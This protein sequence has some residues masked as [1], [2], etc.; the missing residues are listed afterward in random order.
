MRTEQWWN[1]NGKGGRRAAQ[2]NSA[3]V[4]FFHYEK[5]IKSPGNKPVFL[6]YETL[7][8]ND[9]HEKCFKEIYPK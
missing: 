4:P 3:V 1:D 9:P 8:L 7:V 6:W 2:K 5:H